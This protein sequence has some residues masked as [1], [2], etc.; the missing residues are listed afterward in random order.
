VVL[1]GAA[2]V[3][4]LQSNLTALKVDPIPGLLDDLVEDPVTYWEARAALP[5]N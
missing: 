3:A 2:T 1:S 5:W 4:E